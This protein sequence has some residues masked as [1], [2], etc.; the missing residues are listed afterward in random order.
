[1][2]TRIS[3][4]AAFVLVAPVASAQTQPITKRAVVGPSSPVQ[5][6]ALTIRATTSGSL[7]KEFFVAYGGQV[8][9]EFKVKSDGTN[10]AN[11]ETFFGDSSFGCSGSTT[12]AT[13][14]GFG[15]GSTIG[16]GHFLRIIV[17]P[18]TFGQ[19][20]AICCVQLKFN[21]VNVNRNAVA[22]QD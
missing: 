22:T 21:L 9:V 11:W 20:I 6:S 18:T 2:K 16:A 1:M 14:S 5:A 19:R 4:V 7:T 13:Y 3:F 8:S 10:T 17:S 15:C 12:S